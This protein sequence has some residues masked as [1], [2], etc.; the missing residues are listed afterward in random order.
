[1]N[2]VILIGNLSKDPELSTTTSGISVCK[3]DIAVQRRFENA[4]GEREADFFKIIA[5]RGLADN[6]RKFLSKG[7]KAAVVGS[8]QTRTYDDKD[9]VKRYVTEI[10][11]D[12]VEFLSPKQEQGEM[13]QSKAWASL[14]PVTDDDEL[15]DLPF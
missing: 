14:K 12:E 6:C 2:K 5:W 3:F 10:V 7:K 8:L 13:P 11:A 1:M 4:N 15:S 9:G